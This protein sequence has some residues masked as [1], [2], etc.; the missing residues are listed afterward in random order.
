[1]LPVWQQIFVLYFFKPKFL[2]AFFGSPCT[3]EDNFF[4][5]FDGHSDET[6]TLR[7]LLPTLII[8]A[9]KWLIISESIRILSLKLL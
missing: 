2:I 5:F 3:E 9:I 1:M 8:L 6:V 4:R 7:E